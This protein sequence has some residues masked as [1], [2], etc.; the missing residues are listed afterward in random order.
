MLFVNLL[1]VALAIKVLEVLV[2]AP[3][4]VGEF[5]ISSTVGMRRIAS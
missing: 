1:C 3:D 4:D 5:Q 2:R